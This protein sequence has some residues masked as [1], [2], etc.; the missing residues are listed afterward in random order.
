MTARDHLLIFFGQRAALHRR[1]AYALVW[2]RMAEFC[3]AKATSYAE[4]A[5]QAARLAAEALRG[6]AKLAPAH[7]DEFERAVSGLL[8]QLDERD[9]GAA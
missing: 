4:S 1:L 6:Y 9:R 7:N 5:R 3:R 8:S 2:M